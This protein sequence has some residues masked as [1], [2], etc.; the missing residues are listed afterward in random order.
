M[1]P[2]C[3]KLALFEDLQIDT[4]TES[5]LNSI[6]NDNIT[7]ITINSDLYWTPVIQSKNTDELMDF[8]SKFKSN[9]SSNDVILIDDED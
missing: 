9:S 3:N 5:I 4:Y 8:Q 1:C 6:H 7:E 2:V